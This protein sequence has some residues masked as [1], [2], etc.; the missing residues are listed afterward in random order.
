V[1]GQAPRK[2]SDARVIKKNLIGRCG[3]SERDA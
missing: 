1:V 3:G 2:A